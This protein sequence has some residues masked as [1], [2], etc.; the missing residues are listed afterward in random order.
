MFIIC[1]C[2][3]SLRAV[4]SRLAP[5]V[6]GWS[7]LDKSYEREGRYVAEDGV[8]HSVGPGSTY[9]LSNMGSLRKSNHTI[10]PAERAES[11][12]PLMHQQSPHGWKETYQIVR[13]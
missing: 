5:K 11:V 8:K 13:V 2:L 10:L 1:A 3:P 7:T 6:F 9:Q 12:D 4:L